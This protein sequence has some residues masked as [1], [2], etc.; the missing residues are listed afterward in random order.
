[1]IFRKSMVYN[2]YFWTLNL[3]TLNQIPNI[4]LIFTAFN[5]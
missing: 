2:E 1:M 3:L 5:Q 4:T